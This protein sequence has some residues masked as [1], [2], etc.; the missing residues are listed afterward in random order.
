MHAW[1][2]WLGV[3][4]LCL[5]LVAARLG[6]GC[7]CVLGLGIRVFE[8]QACCRVHVQHLLGAWPMTVG[9]GFVWC[10]WLCGVLFVICIVVDEHLYC[11]WNLF[12][13]TFF[14]LG[15]CFFCV[16]VSVVLFSFCGH[17][18]DALALRADEGRGGLRYALGS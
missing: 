18:V 13:R 12:S 6:G 1:P 15:F 17:S 10:W 8:K 11:N 16:F 9:T 2:V 14:V 7:G 4:F 3:C 5:H